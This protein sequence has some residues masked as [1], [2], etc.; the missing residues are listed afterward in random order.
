MEILQG[1]IVD[2]SP[3]GV[4]IFVPYDNID[5]L[6]KREYAD[7]DV[8]F[9]DGRDR[10]LGQIRKAHALMGEIAEWQGQE[11]AATEYDLKVDFIE[12][13]LEGMEK[14]LFS[15]RSCDM[16][17]A[18]EFISYLIDFAVAWNVP[19]NVPLVE[20]CE[21]IKRYVYTCLMHKQ[22]AVCGKRPCDLHH[23]DRIGMGNDRREVQH[24]GRACLPL[25]REHHMETDQLGDT[26]F[27]AKYH[28]ET[29][30]IDEKIAKLYKLNTKGKGKQS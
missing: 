20:Y 18:K 12:N 7:V 11:K 1:K 15:L 21:D 19:T 3:H 24:L 4:T 22:C 8:G 23:V 14:K 26:A 10:S 2:I 27:I 16:T 25:C 9:R 5:R 28:L 13:R 29:V 30:E 6:C 17:T